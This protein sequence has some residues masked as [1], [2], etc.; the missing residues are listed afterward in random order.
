MTRVLGGDTYIDTCKHILCVCVC[1]CVCV[2]AFS[3]CPPPLSRP[4]ICLYG[5]IYVCMYALHMCVCER[6]W[7]RES[8]RYTEVTCPV[9]E[10]RFTSTSK[11]YSEMGFL[12]HFKPFETKE[13]V[14]WPIYRVSVI[15]TVFV[16]SLFK[17]SHNEH[18]GMR[19]GAV[20][21]ESERPEIRLTTLQVA[22]LLSRRKAQPKGVAPTYPPPPE[23]DRKRSYPLEVCFFFTS[24][25][26]FSPY[27]V[28][29]KFYFLFFF[30]WSESQTSSWSHRSRQS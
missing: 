6:E 25:A 17:P 21:I 20:H 5:C 9:Y 14:R 2:C 28:P 12:L 29:G 11:E 1:M 19:G 3:L 22:C 13:L 27:S 7:G 24:E 15:E 18:G 30:A 4:L 8:K 26:C 16:I 10:K 23:Q